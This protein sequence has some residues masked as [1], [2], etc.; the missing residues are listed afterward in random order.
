MKGCKFSEQE[1]GIYREVGCAQGLTLFFCKE[2]IFKEGAIKKKLM[3]PVPNLW[4]YSVR[5]SGGWIM[6][7]EQDSAFSVVRPCMV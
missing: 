5:I 6:R 2:G 4:S 7:R 3:Q 1:H